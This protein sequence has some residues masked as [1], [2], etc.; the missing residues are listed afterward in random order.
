MLYVKKIMYLMLLLLYH[1]EILIL[2]LILDP[3]YYLYKFCIYIEIVWSIGSSF[4][5]NCLR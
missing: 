2:A 3:L 4:L 1:N 5:K